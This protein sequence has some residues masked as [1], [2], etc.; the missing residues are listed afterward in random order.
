MTFRTRMQVATVAC[1]LQVFGCA[2][3]QEAR[4]PS[5]EEV[6]AAKAVAAPATDPFVAGVA[7]FDAGRFEAAKALFQE[8]TV[9]QPANVSAAFNLGLSYEKLGATG[10]A[11]KAYE[12]ARK[13][14]PS[15]KATLLNLGKVLRAQDKFTE[16]IALYE[17]SLK[18]PGLEHDVELL[19]NL[20]VSYRLA[21]RFDQAEAAARRILARTK[22]NADAYKNLALVYFDQG[23][24]RL[25]EFIMANAKKLDDKDPG[26]FN[27]LG[28][29]YLKQD[30]R[31]LALGNFQKSVALEPKFAPGH[32]NLGAM[33]LSYRDY[34]NAE[35]SYAQ[36]SALEPTSYEALLGLAFALDG[37][38]GRDPKKGVAAGAVF[39]KVL[40]IK[41]DAAE[42]V[43]GAAWAY[44]AD[45]TGYDK[46]L[47][48]LGRCRS[49]ASTSSQ[50]QQLIDAKVKSIQS[51]QK[52]GAAQAAPASKEKPKAN[53]QGAGLL[54]KVSDDAAKAEGAPA[55]EAPASTPAP[56]PAPK[57]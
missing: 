56:A 45:K 50:D 7:A 18:L 14:D 41:Q 27:N 9:K 5:E 19:N 10:E 38:K 53:A 48:F 44:S 43:C 37:Q 31:R 21:K 1:A 12:A 54:D 2:T 8:A 49:L 55:A 24:Y 34:A 20:S 52:S 6:Q 40:A 39:E 25:A 17:E 15:H 22:D 46:A 3:T 26:V 16:S 30:E 42:A 13:L 29:I 57:P 23:N 47:G 35:K 33:A 32:M 11:Q 4:K 28:M 51:I 36:A